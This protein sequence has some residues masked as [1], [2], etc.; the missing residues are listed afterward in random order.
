MLT[1]SAKE[2]FFHSSVSYDLPTLNVRGVT[3]STVPALHGVSVPRYPVPPLEHVLIH[4][5]FAAFVIQR[6]CGSTTNVNN[7]YFINPAY[8]TTYA[9]GD[10]CTITVN[11]CNS[12]ICQ[13]R[14]DFLDFTLAQPDQ[15]GLCDLDFLTV[16]GGASI[17]PRICGDNTNQHIYVDF[18]GA[19]AITISIDTA[20]AFIFNRRWNIRIQQ[21][22]CDS[23]WRAPNGCLQYYTT[24]TGTV[25]DFNYGTVV[26]PRAPLVG[27][28][29]LSNLNYGVCIRMTTGFCSIQWTQS[30]TL[31]FTLSG[32]PGGLDPTV[33]GTAMAAVSGVMCTA[34]Y[35]IVPSP[36][37]ANGNPLNVDRFCGNGF[38]PVTTTLKPFVLYVV[39]DAN[40]VGDI[41]NRGFILNYQQI[42]CPIGTIIG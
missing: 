7:T 20:A 1:L 28:R 12:N 10:R 39:T 25:T 15:N 42:A 9:G 23:P 11:R 37:D 22:A 19:T 8:P 26:N 36:V 30:D 17:V 3:I 13:L 18:D 40:E 38:V 24:T 33:I 35:V 14:L 41:A 32:D 4:L 2:S 34:D 16:T 6:T 31:S 5:E 29:Q 27:T 21:I